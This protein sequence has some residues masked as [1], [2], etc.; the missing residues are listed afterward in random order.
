M[1]QGASIKLRGS[2][3]FQLLIYGVLKKFHNALN[4]LYVQL[5]LR[6]CLYFQTNTNMFDS[7]KS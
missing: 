5:F 7:L 3:M 1:Y 4:K 2:G 6:Y